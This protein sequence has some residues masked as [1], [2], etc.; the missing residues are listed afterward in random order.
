[1]N[2]CTNCGHELGVGRFCTNCGSPVPGRHPDAAPS[3]EPGERAQPAAPSTP[4]PAPPPAT[5]PVGSPPPAP[6]YPLY[7]DGPTATNPRPAPPRISDDTAIRPV[8]EMPPFAPLH[9]APGVTSPSTSYDE[10][11]DAPDA[12]R[13]RR[14]SPLVIL[15]AVLVALVVICAVIAFALF[16]S[17]S[18]S[19][20]VQH[21][22]TGPATP[23][24][25]GHRRPGA[26]S[27]SPSAA[28]RPGDL[29]GHVSGVQVPGTAPA[30]VD[31]SGHRVTF[32]SGNLLD[33]D[34]TTAWRVAGDASGRSITITFD[35]PVTIRSVG[36]INGYAKKY[37]GYDGY[38]LNRRVTAVRWVLEDGTT[39]D[40]TLTD[41]RT[42]QSIRVRA[43]PTR[44]LKLEI[45]SVTPPG[46]GK[47]GKDYTAISE[48]GLKGS[49]S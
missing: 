45:E 14:V 46:R 33:G 30:G 28:G 11:P 27:Q 9:T 23:K 38:R 29:A 1:M 18:H 25:H 36:L 5:P 16:N 24:H 17:G 44:S 47:D 37:P 26:A 22:D 3:A 41:D 42:M 20:H 35:K 48:I 39:L 7:A 15:V 21:S 19:N 2:Y 4:P 34:P 31:L 49:A 12:R 10:E 43:R 6:R 40:Q 8:G 32:G 13:R